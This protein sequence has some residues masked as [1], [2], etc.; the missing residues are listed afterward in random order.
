MH[1]HNKTASSRSDSEISKIVSTNAEMGHV[2][3][4]NW[5]TYTRC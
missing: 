1:P 2:Q 5:S 3:T 4:F